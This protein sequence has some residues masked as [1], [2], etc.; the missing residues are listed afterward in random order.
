MKMPIEFAY[1][2]NYQA[3]IGWLQN[4]GQVSLLLNQCRGQGLAVVA[5]SSYLQ[6]IS[7]LSDGILVSRQGCIV[8]EI[9][10]EEANEEM[11]VCAAV[12]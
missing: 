9:L 7:S 12:H 1:W 10:I 8:E 2:P 5:N 3:S 11:I 4:Y 6:E